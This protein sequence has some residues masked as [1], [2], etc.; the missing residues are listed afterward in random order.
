MVAKIFWQL[1]LSLSYVFTYSLLVGIKER[2]LHLY[3]SK[4]NGSEARARYREGY[5]DA[6]LTTLVAESSQALLCRRHYLSLG[7]TLKVEKTAIA[8]T[9]R[10]SS[11]PSI[12]S[13]HPDSIINTSA[14]ACG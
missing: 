3:D 8:T 7:S 9:V 12:L 5:G 13:Q 14:I 4:S 11:M 1:T 6:L 10:E 2:I